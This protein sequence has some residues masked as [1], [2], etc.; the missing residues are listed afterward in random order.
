MRSFLKNL[1]MVLITFIIL[2]MG[3][4]DN[5][6]A[7]DYDYPV[8]GVNELRQGYVENY[9]FP[10]EF[11]Q[12][13]NPNGY[14][15]GTYSSPIIVNDIAYMIGT[16]SGRVIAYD[17]L[18]DNVLWTSNRLLG[19]LSEQ[20]ASPIVVQNRIVI[21][22]GDR[23]NILDISNGRLIK[24]INTNVGNHAWK[25]NRFVS[26]PIHYQNG[27]VYISGWHMEIYGFNVLDN[28]TQPFYIHDDG[29]HVYSGAPVKVGSGSGTRIMFTGDATRGQILMLDPRNG[30]TA[31][32]TV[33]YGIAAS[34]FSQNGTFHISVDK[35]GKVHRTDT[36]DFTVQSFNSIHSIHG[37]NQLM[38][39]EVSYNPGLNRMFVNTNR[40]SDGRGFTY[41]IS[42]NNGSYTQIID[43]ASGVNGGTVATADNKVFLTTQAGAI[44]LWNWDGG[45]A[46]WYRNPTGGLSN[47][48]RMDGARDYSLVVLGGSQR[49]VMMVNGDQG[50]YLFEPSY[51]N[52]RALSINTDKTTYYSNE[53]ITVNASFIN[54]GVKAASGVE[55]RLFSNNS[56]LGSVITRDYTVNQIRNVTLDLGTLSPGTYGLQFRADPD[57]KIA[58]LIETDNN[59]STRTITVIDAPPP[60]PDFTINPNPTDRLITTQFTNHSTHPLDW[61]LSY[62]WEYRI[63]G[64]SSWTQFS[65]VTNPT[66]LFNE[67]AIYEVRLTATSEGISRS[68]TKELPVINRTPIADFNES[69]NPTDRLTNVV[70]INNS[71]DPEGDSMTYKWEH[72]IKGTGSWNQFSTSTNPTY[73]FTQVGIYEVRLTTTDSYGASH[74]RIREVVVNNLA[75]TADFTINSTPTD[76]MSNVAFTNRS[77]DPEGDTMTYRW[78]QRVKGASSWSQ[79]STSANPSFRFS[80][81]GTYEVRLTATDSHGAN[82][83]RLREVV[84]NN[85]TPT[86]NFTESP[87]P[88]D[89][90]RNVQFTNT[91]SD[92]EGDTMTYR[93]EERLKGTSSWSQ[94]STATNPNFRFSEVGTYEVRLTATDAFGASHSRV[95]EVVVNNLAPTANFTESPNPTD[96]TRNVQFTNTSS[97][98]EGDTMTYR[99][100]QRLKGTSSWS[101]FS[102]ATNPNFRFSE[103]GTYEVRLTATDAFGA[104][105]SRVRE[106]VVNNLAPTANF[107]ESPNPTDR[108]RNV[109][110]TNIS[111]D[112]EGDTMTYRWEQRVKGTSGWSQFSTATNPSFRF[113]Q[114][115]TYEVRLTSTDTH[116]ASHSRVREVVVNNLAPTAQFELNQ[117]AY[118]IGDTLQV[119]GRATDPENDEIEYLYTVTQP[120]NASN[121]FTTADFTLGLDQ[122]GEYQIQLLVTDEYGATDTASAT[123]VVNPLTITGYVKHT[124]EWEKKHTS[125]GNN[126]NQFY[127]GETFILEADVSDYPIDK[128]EVSFVGARGN[129]SLLELDTD[130]I[131]HS[132]TLYVGELYDA[133]M[134]ETDTM[135]RNGQVEFE[136]TVQYSNGYITTDKVFVEI[137]GS[138]Y[139]ALNYFRSN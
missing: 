46:P 32:R 15:S 37:E 60:I 93:W 17:V 102:T 2:F 21:P 126:P 44:S 13:L 49:K 81:V 56:R 79:F 69:P 31:K 29:G 9:L 51:P 75:P 117:S 115:G 131:R 121:T 30:N 53:N 67:V 84:I 116:G 5:V 120:N 33:D 125:L 86:A 16:E 88:T 14:L 22:S 112:P 26:T 119:T 62:K 39:Y 104:S 82:H 48:Y 38:R 118:Y 85:L 89:R 34:A 45:A 57:N 12:V 111:S 10:Y 98:P 27:E 1:I 97:D 123:I 80:Q 107:T 47:I 54:D 100:E 136:F 63:K 72:R 40:L 24:S 66:R 113:P 122:T 41:A 25:R 105:H 43:A 83:S 18:N 42:P 36:R 65:T 129:G 23:V 109:Q 128:V 137:I 11:T 94:F 96:R 130:L 108:T 50:V 77:S 99:W 20:P 8:R 70:F 103:V 134:I 139:D 3:I 68:I 28:T 7:S 133:S 90:T 76:R 4:G 91:S 110:F 135:L 19:Q 114:V 127:S 6:Y 61:S 87:N 132:N 64:T 52:I 101:R 59:T 73:R 74:N 35:R 92:P 71:S 138:A 124:E 55:H 78:E 95:R 106:V 58:E